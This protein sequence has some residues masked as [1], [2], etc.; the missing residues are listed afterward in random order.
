MHAQTGLDEKQEG[1]Q[2]S[3]RGQVSVRRL[4][5]A[6]IL[7]SIWPLIEMNMSVTG[8]STAETPAEIATAR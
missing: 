3:K 7:T 2:A 5:V 6:V 8:F 4:G 1:N